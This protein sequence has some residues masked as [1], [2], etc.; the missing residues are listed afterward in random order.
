M[1]GFEPLIVQLL[2]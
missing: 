2:V 1:P